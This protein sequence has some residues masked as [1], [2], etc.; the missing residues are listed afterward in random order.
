MNNFQK[1]FFDNTIGSRQV[2]LLQV[3]VDLGI[4]ATRRYSTLPKFPDTV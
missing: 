3:R 4:M 2:L 1:N